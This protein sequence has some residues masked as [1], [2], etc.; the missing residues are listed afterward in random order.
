MYFLSIIIV[1]CD[2]NVVFI[3]LVV[4]YDYLRVSMSANER[5][6]GIRTKLG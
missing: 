2:T 3:V 5:S 1:P 4:I 6:I